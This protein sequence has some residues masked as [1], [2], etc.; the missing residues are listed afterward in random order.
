MNIRLKPDIEAWLETQVSEGRFG[1]IAEAIETL[2][3]E[4]K[5]SQ[6]ALDSADLSW[7]APYVAKGLADIEAG[8][9]IPAEQVHAELRARFAPRKP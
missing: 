3:E 1:S 9:V 6:A 4:E 8:R 2:V 7:A 5:A